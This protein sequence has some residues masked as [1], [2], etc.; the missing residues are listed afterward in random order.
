MAYPVIATYAIGALNS[1]GTTSTIVVPTGTT[2]GD[3]MILFFTKDGTGAITT[4]TNWTQLAHNASGGQAHGIYYRQ[5]TA[6]LNNFSVSHASEQTTWIIVRIPSGAIPVINTVATGSSTTPNPTS[7]TSGFDT[8]TETLY[9]ASAGWDYNRSCSGFPSN[10]SLYR[11]SSVGTSTGGCGTAIAGAESS[12]ASFDPSSF[13]IG[14]TD[15]WAAYTVAV[16]TIASGTETQK[17]LSSIITTN[18]TARRRTDKLGAASV[19]ATATTRRAVIRTISTAVD[20]AGVALKVTARTFS[21]YTS[22]ARSLLKNFNGFVVERKDGEGEWITLSSIGAG[23]HNY[24]DCYNL[25]NGVTYYYRVKRVSLI[26]GDSGWSNIQ[27]YSYTATEPI[28]K[29]LTTG[30]TITFKARRQSKKDLTEI[31]DV[32]TTTRRSTEVVRS[33]GVEAAGTFRRSITQTLSTVA[34]VAGNLIRQT[35]NRLTGTLGLFATVNRLGA[36]LKTL[37]AEVIA[38]GSVRR[39]IRKR[40]SKSASI[41]VIIYRTRKVLKTLRAT[42]SATG[43]LIKRMA[44][45]LTRPVK[46]AAIANRMKVSLKTLTAQIRVNGSIRRAITR[47]ISAALSTDGAA[48]KSITRYF[49]VGVELVL[50]ATCKT[51]KAF[52]VAANVLANK[53]HSSVIMRIITSGIQASTTVRRAIFKA[54][55]TGANANAYARR[56][57][58][59]WIDATLDTIATIRRTIALEIQSDIDVIVSTFRH[60]AIDI[61]SALSAA[62]TGFDV[63]KLVSMIYY[64]TISATTAVTGAARRLTARGLST[65][66]SISGALFKAIASSS[67]RIRWL[68][69]SQMDRDYVNTQSERTRELSGAGRVL[70]LSLSDQEGGPLTMAYTGDTIR[71]YGRFYNWAGALSDVAGESIKIYDGK[72]TQIATGTP[73]KESTGVYYYEYTIPATYSDP[74]VYEM[75]GTLEGSTILARS[76]IERRWV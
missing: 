71:L 29:S 65:A 42:V 18:V 25:E 41:S 50:T 9:L 30:L 67:K 68:L 4:P 11:Y 7:L 37:A 3:L 46:L 58:R 52:T 38:G 28:D 44:K 16:K 26:L 54:T 70:V 61:V 53:T 6:T 12:A 35:E 76:T 72:G 39:A 27:S 74:L 48:W 63:H 75:S 13:T 60:T 8:G 15:T 57:V 10:M 17:S 69:M 2:S 22:L 55:T 59:K 66:V 34:E 33:I 20:A 51:G 5:L 56:L 62:T 19:T 64:K 47:A 36:F 14:A 49:V 24:T 31:V 43:E 45:R 23:S 1:N 21:G 32:T 73:I 40:L